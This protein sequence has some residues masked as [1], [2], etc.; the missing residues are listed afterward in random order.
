[1]ITSTIKSLKLY[2]KQYKK[3]LQ[4]IGKIV[5][6]L[7]SGNNG[8][9]AL[10][11]TF[12][13][14]NSI[15]GTSFSNAS[16]ITNVFDAFE[17][18]GELEAGVTAIK[19][20]AQIM[21]T[22]TGSSS[23]IQAI[24]SAISGLSDE[25]KYAALSILNLSE[26]HLETIFA[27]SGMT[28]E[29][30]AA[31][32]ATI[33]SG[34]AATGAATG[35]TAFE[36]SVKAAA[37]GLATFL[38]TNPVGWMILGAGAIAGT[39]LAYDFFTESL[40]EAQE[41][42]ASAREEYQNTVSELE[43]L[44]SELETTSSRIDEL[45]SKG[46]LTLT[47]ESE[48]AQLEAQNVALERQK[49]IKEQLAQT[50]A[51]D[52]AEAAANVLTKENNYTTGELAGTTASV[53]RG[54]II[55]ETYAK[56][57]KLNEITKKYN[58]L[59]EEQSRLAES[60]EDL[61][62][63]WWEADTQ[64][65]KNEKQL[66]SYQ[67]QMDSLQNSISENMSAINEEYT[68]LYDSNGNVVSGFEDVAD[69]C[70][71]FFDKMLSDSDSAEAA[72]EKIDSILSRP[73]LEDAKNN[74]IEMAKAS[75]DVGISADDITEKWPK[76]AEAAKNADV[77]IEDLVNTINSMAGIANIDEIKNQLSEAFSGA[78]DEWTS[79]IDGLSNEEI[80]LLYGIYNSE[81]TDA[82]SIDD[83]KVAL[84]EAKANAGNVGEAY[85]EMQQKYEAF[86]ETQNKV[87]DAISKSVSGTG[88]EVG[89]FD[90]LNKAFENLDGYDKSK[91]F[92]T[93]ANGIHLNTEA[94]RE[95]NAQ[96]E[97]QTKLDFA[98]KLSE[99]G[100]QYDDLTEKLKNCTEGSEEY[101]NILSQ[102]DALEEEI[103]GVSMLASQ[104]DGLTSKYQKWIDAQSSADEGNMYDNVTSS[105]DKMKDLYKKGLVGTD[106]FRT[107]VDFM[108][109]GDMSTASVEELVK[110]YEKA[111]KTMNRYFSDGQDGC[112][113]FLEDLHELNSD[114]ASMNDDGN[115][116]IDFNDDEVA[117][118]L[119]ISVEAV[120]AVM[121]KLSDYG[122][123]INL[124]SA[125]A[126]VETLEDKI[127][128][129]E[130]SLKEMGEKPVEINVDA[131]DIDAEI[132]NALAKIQQIND[133]D[134]SAEVKTAQL[135]DANA[136]LDLLIQKKH[137][138]E[139]PSFM[140]VEVTEV[141]ASMTE[142]LQSL[143]DYQNAVNE[144]DSL[145]I[146]G[147][148]TSE[149]EAAQK[150]VDDLAGKIQGL[151]TDTKVKIGLEADGSIDSIKQQI[152]DGEVKVDVDGD[153]TKAKTNIED[154]NGTDVSVEF[155]TSGN[156]ALDNLKSAIAELTGQS[157]FNITASVKVDSQSEL[158]T[159]KET[160]NVLEGKTVDV[161]AN[162]EGQKETQSLIDTINNVAGKIVSVI[163]NVFG[164]SSVDNLRSSIDSLH[165]KTVYINSISTSSSQAQG[166]A[167]ANGTAYASGDWAVK[168]TETA[169]G[170]EIGPELLVRNGK[171]YLIGE[172]G[173][174]MF[175]ARRGDIIFNADQ[176][177]E[178]FT[179]GKITTGN[180]RGKAYALGTAYSGGTGGFY[181]GGDKV[182]GS[183]NAY[184]PKKKKSSSKK[185]SSSKSSSSKSSSSKSSDSSSKDF[186]E[187]F[188][189]IEIAVNRVKTAISNLKATAE[190]AFK[191]FTSRNKSLNKE[192]KQVSKE[193]G[194]QEKAYQRYMQQANSVGLSSYWAKRVRNGSID[195]STITNES[196]A[197]KIKEYQ[198]Y[199]EKAIQAK[200][201]VS[202]L[203]KT[204]A[205]LYTQRMELTQ[206]KYDSR[207]DYY[208]TLSGNIE[209]SVSYLESRGISG[210]KSQYKQIESYTR[211]E[212]KNLQAERSELQ[213]QLNSAVKNGLIKQYSEVWYEWQNQINSLNGEIYSA[214]EKLAE[215]AQKI[216][217]IPLEK[218]DKKLERIN[219]RLEVYEAQYDVIQTA[220]NKNNN[221]KTQNKLAK[222]ES[223]AYNAAYSD[224]TSY[225]NSLWRSSSLRT[226]RRT[227]T[228][229]GKSKGSK[230]STS[231]LN[232]NSAAYQAVL[233][234]NAAIDAQ[235]EAQLE[236]KKAAYDYTLTLRENAKQMFDNIQTAYE[237]RQAPM[238]SLISY[239]NTKLSYRDSMG[240][241]QTSDTQKKV[242]NKL[243]SSSQ[244]L[245]ANQEKEL[246]DL[247]ASYKKN[248][249]KMSTAD[250]RE[251]KAAIYELQEEILETKASI[252]DLQSE[253]NNIEVKKLEI[254]LDK[255]QTKSEELQDAISLKEAKGLDATAS[256]YLSLISNSEKQIDN[257]EKQNELLRKQQEQ[258]STNSEKYQELED[259]IE[260]NE[261]A[262]RDAEK[263]QIEWNNAI[264]EIPLE[265]L[266]KALEL[267]ETISD[268][269]QSVVDL[270]VASGEKVTEADYLKQIQSEN[271]KLAELQEERAILYDYYQKALESEDGTYA[272]KTAD[273]WKKEY[274]E[275][276][277]EINQVKIDI[278][279]LQ[280]E[281]DNI[282]IKRLTN[283]MNDLEH[284][285][286]SL[287][288][289]LD[290]KQTN[291]EKVTE[292][293]YR[294]LINNSQQQVKNLEEQNRLLEEQLSEVEEGSDKY[295]E[296]KGQIQ[297]NE[298]AI[299]QCKKEQAEWNEEIENIPLNELNA[300]LDELESNLESIQ[301][302]IDLAEASGK[303]ITESDYQ[304]MIS[305]SKQQVSNLERQNQL[306]R[307]QLDEC[308]VG[309]DKYNEI[310]Q[311]IADN[312]NSIAQ[313]KKE[314]LEWNDA[315]ANIPL[316]EL[317]AELDEIESK[318]D[319]IQNALDINET[320]GI[321][322]TESDYRQLISASQQEVANLEKQN[323]LLKQQQ[324]ECEVGSEKYNELQSQIN[325]NTNA[326]EQAKQ[327]QA[328]W[329]VA[330]QNL[331]LDRL[332][333][334]LNLLDAI[335]EKNKSEIELKS[336]SGEDL[337]ESDYRQQIS[338]NDA[339]INNLQDRKVE[340]MDNYKKAL[341]ANDGVY[342]GKTA[343][344][345]KAVVN[346]TEA[347][348]NDLK[349]ENEE[350]KDS[351]RDDV[352]WRTFER[353]HDEVERTTDV[354][355]GISDLLDDDMLY[356]SEGNM[357]QYGIDKVA[358]LVKQYELA[359]KEVQNYS[360]DIDN[361]N[362]LY[363]N[364]QY[365]EE[366]YNEKLAELQSGL[367]DAASDMKTYQDAVVDMYKN[368]EQA[369]LDA[370][371][372]VIDARNSALAS[373][374]KYYDFDKT[375]RGKTKDI[376]SLEAQ[377][378][379][380]ENI[381]GAEA[382]AKRAKLQAELSEAQEDLDDTLKEH[383][384]EIAQESLDAMKDTLQDAFDD[385]WNDVTMGMDEIQK[386]MNE[387]N[388]LTSSSATQISTS[389]N[390]LLSYYGI[391]SSD[392][393]TGSSNDSSGT[394]GVTPDSSSDSSGIANDVKD[395]FSDVYG[396]TGTD[397]S[398]IKDI[399]SDT[400]SEI[401]TGFDDLGNTFSDLFNGMDY[402]IED[403]KMLIGQIYDGASFDMESIKALLGEIQNYT[404]E[405]IRE[406]TAMIGSMFDQL[407][408][409]GKE[410]YDRITNVSENVANTSN[411]T[412]NVDFNIDKMGQTDTQEIR[413][414]YK[415]FYQYVDKRL[416]DE[417]RSYGIKKKV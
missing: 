313:C 416:A 14:L 189:W 102:R 404:P 50:Q 228:N 321:K 122:F 59:Q 184:K 242:Y 320:K 96:Y 331:P 93:T 113:K 23:D 346:E 132:D 179:N 390:E 222:M 82:W 337:T 270:K 143:K 94:L 66:A 5:S 156:E 362:K 172:N 358:L 333:D 91:L 154:I 188:D 400:N 379:A 289:E 245:L 160:I 152:A 35:F 267:I 396:D 363:A 326:I 324:A 114:W 4:S 111:N 29:E 26:A 2:H 282:D 309:S 327:Q 272:G 251:A 190:N 10:K 205:E 63:S 226:A 224:V 414:L 161:K 127:K 352:Y 304:N 84:E 36:T 42:S 51:K 274:I 180:K 377:L 405:L 330:I 210:T 81:N 126:S 236:A 214:S 334:A 162:V 398:D 318:M 234:Y 92:E 151:D 340:A 173:A 303:K 124:D 286:S 69:A 217:N 106:D 196:L 216:A 134:V 229:K 349:I 249:S 75:D 44:N 376:Q 117:K 142:A 77:D 256:D 328:E 294:G 380:L 247:Q 178:I 133:S 109:Y 336:A 166:T 21:P 176:T 135:D 121:R 9:N 141:K 45:K 199:Y 85:A 369:E 401:N 153:T 392:V 123:D 348:I 297:D 373:K 7:N 186:E 354:L 350:L 72:Q 391:N 194:I 41:K 83:W 218:L 353:M 183:S 359:R 283:E 13:V 31:T 28:A 285:A 103:E 374:K 12:A 302:E 266:E 233:N 357:T 325:S 40:D 248:A 203:K 76:L 39:V 27:A 88:I 212:I 107:G 284:E 296:I 386:L 213:K 244:S 275:L 32:A 281:I 237:S 370:I 243:I 316:D 145:K 159:L 361:L 58:D 57:E 344:E 308:E 339:Q 137:E 147:A 221:L 305:N 158:D 129:T 300:E 238:N 291:G 269:E 368:M 62:S 314:Q 149:I 54:T 393:N 17:K 288:N 372:E 60:G 225:V 246:A 177:R 30:A 227:S 262:I 298:E 232:K 104:F 219:S 335:D 174:E 323:Q 378:A 118:K 408:N 46:A 87:K 24:L 364:G 265:E 19:E 175:Q 119:G 79:F 343:D 273:E 259:Q 3:S 73:T 301:N 409:S 155:T 345:W 148:D 43:S 195:I 71:D 261:S 208:N 150:K 125:T 15:G 351:L 34:S 252:A 279:E 315:I 16:N 201:A 402:S 253:L 263:A 310:Q 198:T 342:G 355:Q 187:T 131:K 277:T 49:A 171:T 329:N 95:L 411:N 182:T 167:H 240:Y 239:Y 235:R 415:E 65:E 410:L 140:S 299:A 55:D 138:T 287:Q 397:V 385:R 48:L 64:Y 165:S 381:S 1:M 338:D 215:Y 108:T 389:L 168:R 360:N 230:L 52:A 271:D 120:Q 366:E 407:V 18:L 332:E 67:K 383:E 387:A 399:V 86:Y 200:D 382:D 61:T 317:N 68:S 209:S 33:A 192:I 38:T 116:E 185:S 169:L 241:S 100:S 163:A 394:N 8:I 204:E 312:E 70:A 80:K 258:Y 268:Y 6:T 403:F 388:E 293:D 56:Q 128:S 37:V 211:A 11:E 20:M 280:D 260:S 101:N 22:F 74:L 341:A 276:D 395:A 254:K 110:A 290:S 220:K 157:P 181:A 191:S 89:T 202:E 255:L 417:L 375:I 347:S 250:A 231:G 371:F 144:L 97:A 115:W 356:D 98:N 206:T 307:Q 136:K 53:Q 25:A 264:A 311:Q 295:Y 130:S 365:T 197:D 367:L 413:K 319:S 322:A 306:L 164:K 193:I 384:F 278:I 292:S 112:V 170:G 146:K 139:N 90:E 412:F 207:V 105:L 78:D 223:D 47:E 99:L 257:L 406:N